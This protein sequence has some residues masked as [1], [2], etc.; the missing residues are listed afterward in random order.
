MADCFANR[1]AFSSINKDRQVPTA[2][3]CAGDCLA[4]WATS[5][6]YVAAFIATC[7]QPLLN[8]LHSFPAA[9]PLIQQ[10]GFAW[11]LQP[12]LTMPL[13]QAPAALT[14]QAAR[15]SYC[16]AGAASALH[17]LA[18]SCAWPAGPT[19]PGLPGLPDPHAAGLKPLSGLASEPAILACRTS[20]SVS[21]SNSS[22][23]VNSCC[24][25]HAT[26][27]MSGLAAGSASCPDAA[28]GA[29]LSALQPRHLSAPAV[30]AVAA[31]LTAASTSSAKKL[32]TC[33]AHGVVAAKLLAPTLVC[34][35]GRRYAAVMAVGLL[36]LAT[37]RKL[38]FAGC[39]QVSTNDQHTMMHCSKESFRRALMMLR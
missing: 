27:S 14:M 28:G 39:C 25:K 35:L 24:E 31:Y 4:A 19:P 7:S 30:S 32:G 37:L 1:C 12:L 6:S 11:W 5:T 36:Q 10:P 22:H 34:L 3:A 9:L 2:A 8:I 23:A 17:L 29:G 21:T 20:T 13:L 16:L 26:G 38:L 18:Y 15:A 33:A